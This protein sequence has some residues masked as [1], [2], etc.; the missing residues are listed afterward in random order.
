MQR[1]CLASLVLAAA[2]AG[3]STP[4]SQIDGVRYHRTQ[5]DTYPL[6]V[7]AVDGEGYLRN[8]VLVDPGVHR[9]TVVA[10]PTSAQY[11][12]SERSIQLDVKPCTQYHLVAVKNNR[13]STNFDVKVDQ[14]ESVPGCVRP[15]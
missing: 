1:S 14:E 6:S 7:V 13:L 5:I 9:V 11:Y 10:P 4:Y 8:P 12:G 3:C 2:L 15:G